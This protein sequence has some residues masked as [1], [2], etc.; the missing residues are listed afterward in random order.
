MVSAVEAV[1]ALETIMELRPGVAVTRVEDGRKAE[2]GRATLNRLAGDS[3]LAGS[4]DVEGFF[5]WSYGASD[6]LDA[7]EIESRS[8]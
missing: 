1:V 4:V 3:I 6:V 2:T 7:L 5:E 8:L